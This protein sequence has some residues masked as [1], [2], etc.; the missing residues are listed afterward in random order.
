MGTNQPSPQQVPTPGGVS[1]AQAA[2]FLLTRFGPD[3]R[4]VTSIGYGEWSKAYAFRRGGADFIAR[5]G[6]FQ[7]DFAKDRLAAR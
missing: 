1:A 2:A 3:I 6:A 4:D 7:E 5:F